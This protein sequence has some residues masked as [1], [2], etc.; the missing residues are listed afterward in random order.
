M[1]CRAVR[2]RP[3]RR[4]SSRAASVI[5]RF[6]FVGSLVQPA[7]PA[8][9]FGDPFPRDGQIFGVTIDGFGVPALADAARRDSANLSETPG[10][11]AFAFRRQNVR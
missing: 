5:T 1:D 6:P 3:A 9:A 7:V 10:A 2:L 4:L 8:D 11:S